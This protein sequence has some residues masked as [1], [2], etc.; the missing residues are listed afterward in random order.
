[1]RS[2]N[3]L[4]DAILV[5]DLEATCWRGNPPEGMHNEIIEIGIAVV[6]FKT[7]EILS[8]DSIIVKPQFSEISEF[9]TELTTLTKEFVDTNGISFEDACELLRTKYKSEARLWASWGKYDYNQIVKDCELKKVKFPMGRD[10]Y[11]LKPLFSFKHGIKK[12]LGVGGALSHLNLEF[13]GT[14]HRGNDDAKNI[15]RM[16]PHIF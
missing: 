9:C 6:D 8:N 15:A 1:M 5:V 13:E 14:Q 12:D 11:N 10:H 16:L 7:K 2:K 3:Q 4:R